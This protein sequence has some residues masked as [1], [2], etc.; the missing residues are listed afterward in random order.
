M[1]ILRAHLTRGVLLTSIG[2]D[3]AVLVV[4]SDVMV[5]VPYHMRGV[6]HT[7]SVRQHESKENAQ[8][9]EDTLIGCTIRN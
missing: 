7:M 1:F 6:N 3:G 8:S 5:T 9:R 4:A 2:A